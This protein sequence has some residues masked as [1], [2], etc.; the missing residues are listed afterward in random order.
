MDVPFSSLT[1][2]L[3]WLAVVLAIAYLALAIRQ[4]ILCWYC[5]GASSAIYV[6]LTFDAGLVM[7][8]ALNAFYVAMAVYGWWQWRGG[9]AGDETPVVLWPL[10]VHVAAIAGVALGASLSTFL[11]ASGTGVQLAR[12]DAVADAAIAFAAV[13]ATFLI[14]RKELGNWAWW[15][16]IDIATV[17]LLVRQD[18]AT[19][20][21][22]FAIYLVMIPFGFL[23]W[24][25]SYDNPS[26]AV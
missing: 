26:V 7:Q 19:A 24:R 10:R 18:L 4:S 8:A 5:G 16:V 15:F 12:A 3:S 17:V 2:S 14:A 1:E 6:Y 22:P 13:W 21:I 25:R 23:S 20:A 11:F 9:V